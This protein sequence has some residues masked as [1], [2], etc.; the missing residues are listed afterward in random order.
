MP[1]DETKCCN[2]HTK[3]KEETGECC[4]I[5]AQRKAEQETYE[6]YTKIGPKPKEINE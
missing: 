4:Q 3:E 6:Y 5:G 1:I 2:T